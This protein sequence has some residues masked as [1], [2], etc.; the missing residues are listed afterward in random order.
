MGKKK[1]RSGVLMLE[2]EL[3]KPISHDKAVRIGLRWADMLSLPLPGDT[4][5]VD[6]VDLKITKGPASD[7]VLLDAPGSLIDPVWRCRY[8][9]HEWMSCVALTQI[10]RH[11]P[12]VASIAVVPRDEG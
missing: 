4:I 1:S 9:N 7:D 2:I 5:T 12:G 3:A 8:E 10:L 6:R 11:D